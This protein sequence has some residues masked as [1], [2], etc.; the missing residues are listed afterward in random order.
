MHALQHPR[1]LSAEQ[2]QEERQRQD[3]D[4]QGVL[5]QPGKRRD[6]EAGPE[7]RQLAGVLGLHGEDPAEDLAGDKQGHDAHSDNRGP[8]P[9]R[10]QGRCD[11]AGKIGEA[12]HRHTLPRA[13]GSVTISEPTAGG[14][15]G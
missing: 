6:D 2:K 4:G 15:L 3:R 12:V 11:R 5:E 1:Q 8:L 10:Q 14:C 9:V 13:V 7:V